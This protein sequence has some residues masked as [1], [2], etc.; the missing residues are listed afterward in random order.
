[1][2]CLSLR[3]STWPPLASFVVVYGGTPVSRASVDIVLT[4]KWMK[5]FLSSGKWQSKKSKRELDQTEGRE[6]KVG[7]R[8]LGADWESI[9]SLLSVLSQKHIWRVPAGSH[10][11]CDTE[12]A[13][14]LQHLSLRRPHTPNSVVWLQPSVCRNELSDL[15]KLLKCNRP[16]LTFSSIT[17]HTNGVHAVQRD[18]LSCCLG[19]ILSWPCI[20]LT[21]IYKWL[22]RWIWTPVLKTLVCEGC[23][24]FSAVCWNV[25]VC[26]CVRWVCA[27]ISLLQWRF[28]LGR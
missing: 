10:R 13:L 5:W 9:C 28:F 3:L 14:V 12:D 16:L 6:W 20:L 21:R 27:L 7:I 2:T 23:V 17:A 8:H 4:S 11:T 15:C 1:M 25:R 24:L 26:A 19:R 22:R 18:T